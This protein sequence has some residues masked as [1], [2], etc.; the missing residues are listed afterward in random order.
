MTVDKAFICNAFVEPPLQYA[1][2]VDKHNVK[3]AH[4]PLHPPNGRT[5][6]AFICFPPLNRFSKFSHNE[7][8]TSKVCS[9]SCRANIELVSI[10]L[11]NRLRFFRYPIPAPPSAHLTVNFPITLTGAGVIRAYPVPLIIQYGLGF[12]LTPTVQPLCSGTLYTKILT[13][14]LLVQACQYLWLVAI[15][16]ATNEIHITL[17]IPYIPSS[18][19]TLVL[20]E[21]GYHLTAF[22][23]RIDQTI[24]RLHCP[25]SFTPSNCSL[26]M[27]R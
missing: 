14:H 22:P 4:A 25:D 12:P 21:L 23:S 1:F 3:G 8:P 2:A 7:T 11:Q 13:A 27:C 18:L 15:N 9:L 19:T 6:Q 17:A 10:P 26:R 16:G 20:A 24:R 5:K